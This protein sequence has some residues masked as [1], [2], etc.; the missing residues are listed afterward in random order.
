MGRVLSTEAED[1]C[2][3]PRAKFVCRFC[4]TSSMHKVPLD[5][6]QESIYKQRRQVPG[7]GVCMI[8]F[9]QGHHE[10]KKIG[11]KRCHNL[12]TITS[13]VDDV[14]SVQPDVHYKIF[15]TQ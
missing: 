1:E 12:I 3:G 15:K 11:N 5:N 6:S 10:W 9:L 4:G 13:R 8:I 2:R 14:C 7:V